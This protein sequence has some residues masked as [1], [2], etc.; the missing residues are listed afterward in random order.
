MI[1]KELPKGT[2]LFGAIGAYTIAGVLGY[3]G[4]GI[5]YSAVTTG[6]G[7][8]RKVALK[9][10]FPYGK[11]RRSFA[12][13]SP[14]LVAIDPVRLKEINV[15]RNC[16]ARE[17]RILQTVVHNGIVRYIEM[18]QAHGTFYLVTE[19]LD[20]MTLKELV[21][22]N[23]EFSFKDAFN[24]ILKLS[25][26][27]S[28]L[29]SKN[30]VHLD[31]KPANVILTDTGRII[32]LDFGQATY[33]DSYVPEKDYIGGFSDRYTAP[34]IKDNL[35]NISVRC[36]VFSLGALFYN[37]ITGKNPPEITRAK[38]YIFTFDESVPDTF[39]L[40]I[41]KAMAST[42]KNRTENIKA[43]LEDLNLDDVTKTDNRRYSSKNRY[44][45]PSNN[46]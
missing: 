44:F 13:D 9:E 28:Y 38:K 36:D 6:K 32:L 25:E 10:L 27:L 15:Y 21:Y 24:I 46:I 30:V 34:E 11:C 41:E 3:G 42:P 1:R 40:A 22:R 29:H 14:D 12:D 8:P 33:L 20:G 43:F 4:F 16:F 18:F 26:I 7:L 19:L 23:E 31:V 17:G 5:I 45:A 37:L 39:R 35:N 2:V